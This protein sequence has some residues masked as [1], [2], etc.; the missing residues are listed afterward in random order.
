M[1]GLELRGQHDLAL[2]TFGR[3]RG[4]Y[5]RRQELDDDTPIELFVARDEDARHA[6]AAELALED[7]L[8][9]EVGLE[10]VEQVRHRV[11]HTPGTRRVNAGGW[12]STTVWTARP[13]PTDGSRVAWS[14]PGGRQESVTDAPGT[15]HT[16]PDR[17]RGA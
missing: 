5:L 9:S 12:L 3:D 11:Q 10:V 7:V 4:G 13:Q 15:G 16:E 17:E 14:V 2:E 1:F 6:T 8:V